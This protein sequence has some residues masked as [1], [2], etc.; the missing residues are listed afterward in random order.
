MK[1]NAE[2][3]TLEPFELKREHAERNGA[4]NYPKAKKLR[5]TEEYLRL[6]CAMNGCHTTANYQIGDTVVRV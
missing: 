6:Y 1:R 4:S 2:N 5:P 3:Q